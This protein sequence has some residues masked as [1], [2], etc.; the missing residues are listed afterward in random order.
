MERH[1]NNIENN[2]YDDGILENKYILQFKDGGH[3]FSDVWFPMFETNNTELHFDEGTYTFNQLS[4][5]GFRYVIK[6]K[7]VGKTIINAGSIG[8]EDNRVIKIIDMTLNISE[9]FGLDVYGDNFNDIHEISY[10]VDE[11]RANLELKNVNINYSSNYIPLFQIDCYQYMP[12]LDIN[13]VK[14]ESDVPLFFEFENDGDWSYDI[15]S[16]IVN[17]LNITNS[18]FSKGNIY[19]GVD[20]RVNYISISNT[21]L[22]KVYADYG[23]VLKIDCDSTFTNDIKKGFGELDSNDFFEQNQYNVYGYSYIDDPTDDYNAT[24]ITEICKNK[25]IS[26][27]TSISLEKI[28]EE[29]GY[30]IDDTWD[31]NPLGIVEIKDEK[32]VPIKVGKTVISKEINGELQTLRVEVTPDQIHN[33]IINPKTNTPIIVL[34]SLLTILFSTIILINIRSMRKS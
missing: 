5:E 19:F 17:N 21:K 24:I 15:P 11:N 12:S 32:I 9:Y 25:S 1:I 7:G 23:I 6:G 34:I 27:T 8:S 3:D 10:K 20:G 4:L 33:T 2:D 26:I 13:N 14:Y 18:D 31:I 29:F 16:K 22:N 28:K 30:N